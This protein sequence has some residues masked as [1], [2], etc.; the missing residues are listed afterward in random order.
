MV[1]CTLF[2]SHY[3]DKGLVMYDS[4]KAV[5]N[6]FKFYV[7]AFDDKCYEVLKEME[8]DSLI[9]ISMKEF[10][11][12]ELLQVK[13]S[14]SR[15]EYCWTCSSHAIAYIL[16]HFETKCTYIDADMYFYEDPQCVLDEMEQSNC[17]IQIIEQRFDDRTLSRQMMKRSGKYCVEFNTFTRNQNS[18]T[19]LQWWQDRCL[20]SCTVSADGKVFGDQKYLDDWLERFEGVHVVE[21]K[22]AGVAPWNITNYELLEKKGENIFLQYLPTGERCKLIFYHFHNMSHIGEN[23]INIEVY[24]R[25]S[26]TSEALVEEIYFPYIKQIEKKRRLLSEKYGIDYQQKEI[27]PT[28]PIAMLQEFRLDSIVKKIKGYNVFGLMQYMWYQKN[29]KKDIIDIS[30]IK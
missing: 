26:K 18:R 24:S 2:D 8:S 16:D 30:D 11:S 22:G 12:E 25:A 13:K 28:N 7:I 17:Q 10:E 9:P 19:V 5:S 1:F 21:N 4:L 20:E 6:A 27:H 15:G 14:R 23:K 3:L 29:R